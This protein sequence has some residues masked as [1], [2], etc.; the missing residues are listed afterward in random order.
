MNNYKKSFKKRSNNKEE[1]FFDSSSILT[2]KSIVHT[3]TTNS[4]PIDTIL[5]SSNTSNN[6][7]YS[8]P[9]VYP[10]L[11]ETDLNY[12]GSKHSEETEVEKP[13]QSALFF[14]T[15]GKINIPA[16]VEYVIKR[17]VSKKLLNKIDNNE[18][19]AIE[20][21]L[22]FLSRFSFSYF[23]Y[24]GVTTGKESVNLK[25]EYLQKE[26]G[27]NY[28]KIIDALLIGSNKG[29]IIECDGLAIDNVKSYSY[30][31]TDLYLGKGIIS[32][33]L[34][35]AKA[36]KIFKK[37]FY[38]G[39][40]KANNNVITKNLM[41][42]YGDI[43]LP[44]V[45]MVKKEAKKLI[46]E[47][48]VTKNGRVL[49]FK[50][51]HKKDYWSDSKNRSFVE[52]YIEL[53]NY[54]TSDGLMIPRVGSERSGGRV[55]DSFTLMPSWI[56][57]MC[58]IGGQRIVEADYSALHPNL[59]AYL[60]GGN[61]SVK[62]EEIALEL[63]IEK[64]EVKVEHLSFFNKEIWQMK[65]SPLYNYYETREKDMLYN[66]LKDKG[67]N[68]YK[69]TSKKMFTMEVEIMTE[70]IKRLNKEGI[71]VGYVY[72]ALFCNPSAKLQVVFTM[73]EVAKEKNIKTI[74]K[75]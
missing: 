54:L 5:Y 25:A 4:I 66:I 44:S 37:N 43:K 56:R 33:Q 73:N 61:G 58:K 38:I 7:T 27:R 72:D 42:I 18:R 48:Y 50:N 32:Y 20:M 2:G 15:I 3:T 55:I 74:V 47:K 67:D 8:P 63:N 68:G 30:K 12:Y 29:P 24:K 21:C 28:K 35:S 22:I 51:R 75:L 52:D 34:K 57:S 17:Y 64:R 26:F 19:V 16:K 65:K 9:F 23:V 40:S 39:L 53:Y 69:V 6:Y 49:T 13:A 62:H 70:C 46:S 41:N 45:S 36:L 59:A 11:C 1:E 60:Y 71:Y 31:L 14:K 10:D